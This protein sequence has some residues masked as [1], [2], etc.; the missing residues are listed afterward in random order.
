MFQRADRL[1]ATA[2]AEEKRQRGRDFE[3]VLEGM[4]ADEGLA[5][6]IRFRPSGEEIDGSFF[7]RGRGML[8]EAKWTQDPLPASSIYQFRGKVEGKLVGTIGVFI[9]MSGFSADT[10]NALRAGKVV[11]TILFDGDDMRAVADR[12]VG[13]AEALDR[14]LRVA[15]DIGTPFWPLRDP[16]SRQLVEVPGGEGEPRPTIVV[17]VEGYFDAL[18]VHALANELGPSPYELEV[19]PAGGTFN[20]AALANEASAARNGEPVIIADGDGHPQAVRRQIEGDL[21]EFSSEAVSRRSIFVFDPTF[22]KA[23]GVWEG[24]V[25]G[26]RRGPEFDLQL[27]SEKVRNTDIRGVAGSNREVERLLSRLGL[28]G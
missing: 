28:D 15:A 8:F 9:S 18:L 17:I 6:R 2:S 23:L 16:V 26:R 14:K 5:P 10:V 11:N 24:F 19:L 20:L 22:G 25:E 1:E 4:L 27:W 3:R 21:D 7:H 13:F 12:Q